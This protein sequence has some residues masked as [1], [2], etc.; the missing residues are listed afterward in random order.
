M[1][2][3]TGSDGWM[4]IESAPRDGTPILA[5][6]LGYGA[7][8]TKMGRYPEGSPGYAVWARGDGPLNYGWVWIEEKH[9]SAHTWNPTHWMPLPPPPQEPQP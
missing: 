7:R 6:S 3:N 9:N 8:E 1:T 2:T 4:P 5:W